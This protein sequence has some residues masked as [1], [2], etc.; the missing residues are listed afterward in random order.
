M[1]ISD[2]APK[3]DRRRRRVRAAIF[4]IIGGPVVSLST[5]ALSLI[6]KHKT[7]RLP[8]QTIAEHKY[9]DP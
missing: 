9:K 8:A 1:Q 3:C 4:N 5:R 7:V 6:S 2:T